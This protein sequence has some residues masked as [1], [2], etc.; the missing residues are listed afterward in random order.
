LTEELN[1]QAKNWQNLGQFYP[2]PGGLDQK[3]QIFLAT[4]L[5]PANLENSQHREADEELEIGEFTRI[6]IDELI[7]A[8]KICDNWTLAGLYIY[9]KFKKT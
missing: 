7:K 8:G 6:E 5:Q 3:Y 9:D 1:L 2:D 4:D